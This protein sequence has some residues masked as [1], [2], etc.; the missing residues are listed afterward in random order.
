MEMGLADER[1]DRFG[2]TQAAQT[3]GG[4][5]HMNS[6]RRELFGGGGPFAEVCAEMKGLRSRR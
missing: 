6:L 4:E 5:I 3:R 1:P 2:A